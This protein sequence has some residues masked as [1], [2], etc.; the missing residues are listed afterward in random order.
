V[1]IVGVSVDTLESHV[2]FAAEHGLSY[3][4][5]PDGLALARELGIATALKKYARRTTYLVD[6]EGKVQHI[7]SVKDA[8]AHP[9]E[10][11]AHLREAP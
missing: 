2:A 3:D 1:G 11:L 7:W 6:A 4:L 9:A 8:H 10:V 5:V